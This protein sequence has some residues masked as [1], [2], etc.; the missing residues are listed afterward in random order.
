MHTLRRLGL[1]AL[2]LGFMQVVFGA[3]VRITGSGLGCGEHWP[4]CYGSFTPAH[5]GAAL[6]IEISHRYG[7]AALSLAVLALFIAAWMK[8]DA[9]PGRGSGGVLAAAAA[10]LSLGVGAA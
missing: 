10:A 6:L 5:R 3:I 4:D 7:A 2:F 1:V 8:R 9:E